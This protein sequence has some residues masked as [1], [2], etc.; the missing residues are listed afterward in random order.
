NVTQRMHELGVRVALGA[1]ARD[2]LRLV[3]G[4]GL[5]VG[6]IGVAI[7][8]MLAL[9]GSRWLQPL[10]YKESARDPLTYAVIGAV[11]LLV[12][13]VSSTVPALRAAHADPNRALR[14][15]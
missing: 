2:I 9:I 15:E 6:A 11:M 12:A 3:V 7:G 8:L 13:I 5:A 14:G 10:L 4:E 1:Q